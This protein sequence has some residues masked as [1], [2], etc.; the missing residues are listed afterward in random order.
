MTTAGTIAA[1]LTLDISEFNRG[2]LEAMRLMLGLSEAGLGSTTVLGQL[3]EIIGVA[4]GLLSK[5]LVNSLESSNNGFGNFSL[6]V[7]KLM[8][9]TAFSIGQSIDKIISE[10]FS[11]ENS[12]PA[13]AQKS[14]VIADSI[15]RPFQSLEGSAYS[16]MSNV[17]QGFANG[18]NAKKSLIISTASGIANS[19]IKTLK[20]VLRIASPSKV[21]RTI[22]EQ[23][24]QGFALGIGDM[25]GDIARSA[26][27]MA[28][29]VT[30]QRRAAGERAGA[31]GD[32]F[33]ALTGRL[34][35]LI[36]LLSSGG[37][38]VMQV[39]GRAFARLVREYS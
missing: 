3:S 25:Q 10:I 37:E 1:S 17:G 27:M 12:A 19:A 6:N 20:S 34:D 31:G 5:Q 7:I 16:I 29:A 38:Q 30:G 2:I 32:S 18:L 14:E 8:A 15:K 11:I 28:D 36:S 39:D 13:A 35:A 33:S 9:G 24:A 23:T 21:M 26:G 22:G 4:A